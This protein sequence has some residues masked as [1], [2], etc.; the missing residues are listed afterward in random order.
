M[1]WVIAP[2]SYKG[3]LD[4]AGVAQAM[5]EGIA[6]VDHQAVCVL[7]PMADGGEGTLDALH[8]AVGGE[9][10]C[11]PVCNAVGQSMDVGCLLLP[12]GTVVLEVARIIGLP[13]A[14]NSDV[15]DRSSRGVGQLLLALV[16]AGYRRIAV[17]LGGS[18]TND[19]GA[20]CLAAMGL[21]LMDEAGKELHGCLQDLASVHALNADGLSSCMDGISLEVWSDVENPL[22]GPQGATAVF[23]PQKG[24]SAGDIQEVDGWIAH[25]AGLLDA[26]LPYPLRDLPGSGAAGGLG[27]A[28]QVLG[29]RMA[30]G[31]QAVARHIGLADEIASADWVFTGEG[32][33]DSQTLSGKAPACVASLA[34]QAGVPVS[35]LSG[36]IIA[37]HAG[38]LTRAF[39]G[40]YSLCNRPMTLGEAM[41]EAQERIA[42]QTEQLA[43]TILAVRPERS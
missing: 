1:R 43:R 5:Q 40:C 14:G 31:A 19:A 2:D 3:S 22:I 4:A 37:D 28:L 41:S 8:A 39:D 24:V 25:F 9:W 18:S 27:Y 7:R 21:Q 20:G 10:L 6:R 32:R 15:K 34:R 17:A 29:G 36:A 13:D 12:D 11:Y 16:C 30:S 26:G 33:S 38:A 35:L 42:Q 23:G